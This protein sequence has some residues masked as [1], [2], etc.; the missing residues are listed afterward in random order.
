[1]EAK[2]QPQDLRIGNLV[3]GVSDRIEKVVCIKEDKLTTKHY[4]GEFDNDYECEIE[5]FSPIPLSEDILKRMGFEE[6]DGLYVIPLKATGTFLVIK[7]LA[8]YYWI[9]YS[10]A[11]GHIESVGLGE[12][13]SVHKAQNLYYSLTGSELTIKDI[14]IEG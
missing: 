2:I 9:E 8:N 1:M 3:Y 6:V 4:T 11:H 10:D 14:N 12:L 13:T 5:Y 7:P